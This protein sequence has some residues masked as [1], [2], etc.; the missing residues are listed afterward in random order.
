MHAATPSPWMPS[1]Y[2]AAVV[3]DSTGSSE[4]HS[5]FRPASGTRGMFMVGPSW[6]DAP[7]A[8]ASRPIAAAT[9]PTRAG[10]KVA[11][12]ATPDAKLVEVAPWLSS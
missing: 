7:A 5:K 11:P 1:T 12:I 6:T 2:A 3:P 10:S 8:R 9:S 4:K